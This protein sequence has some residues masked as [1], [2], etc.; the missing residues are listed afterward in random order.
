MQVTTKNGQYDVKICNDHENMASPKKVRMLV[1]KREKLLAEFEAKAKELGY[2]LV[3]SGAKNIIIAKTEPTQNENNTEQVVTPTQEKSKTQPIIRKNIPQA[4]KV[5]NH[6]EAPSYESYA[7]PE[8]APAV[9]S[10]EEQIV[11]GRAGRPVAIPKKI[12]SAAGTTDVNIVDTGGDAALQQ[13]FKELSEVS[14]RTE[15]PPSFQNGYLIRECVLCKGTGVTIIGNKT[16][17]KCKGVGT[18]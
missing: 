5:P 15:T 9:V 18:L 11:Q 13:R 6:P 8:G 3:P 16:C 2:Q 17:P 7:I 1:E 12:V 4:I 14:K 10:R